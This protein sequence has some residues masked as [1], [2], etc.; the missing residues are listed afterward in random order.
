MLLEMNRQERAQPSFLL[1]A[2]VWKSIEGRGKH[3]QASL[4]SGR[5]VHCPIVVQ[6]SCHGEA[7]LSGR[8]SCLSLIQSTWWREVG[9]LPTGV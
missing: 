4:G 5:T 1:D 8:L 6:G 3:S 2:T 7:L 9:V